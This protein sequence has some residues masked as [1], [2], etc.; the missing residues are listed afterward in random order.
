MSKKFIVAVPS[1]EPGGL[2]AELAD[3]FGH[4]AVFTLATIED[5]NIGDMSVLDNVPHVQGGCMAPINH[6]AG[7]RVRIIIAGGMGMTPL[8]GFNTVGI[9][10]FHSNG[11]TKV[12]DAL[13]A[14]TEGRLPRFSQNNTCGGGEA[15]DHHEGG[16]GN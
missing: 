13:T 12:G 5:G 15:N 14:L 10:V 4:C 2:E 7:N 3:H 6:L 16:C 11:F 1:N 8:A 9:D